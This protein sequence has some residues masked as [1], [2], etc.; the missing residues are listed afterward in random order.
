MKKLIITIIALCT[1]MFATPASAM[2]VA[3]TVSNTYPVIGEVVTLDA[4]A[5][6][7]DVPP[8]RYR[9]W[10]SRRTSS[11]S[12]IL[13]AQIGEGVVVTYAWNTPGI[14][15]ITLA[16]SNSQVRGSFY[17]YGAVLVK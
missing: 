6:V 5:T 13:G 7:C 16:V 4:S 3:F 17:A 11:G 12:I 14:K 2:P 10:W 1:L 9:W 8:C 15:Y